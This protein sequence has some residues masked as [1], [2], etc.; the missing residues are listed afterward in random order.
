MR[1]ALTTAA[2]ASDEEAIEAVVAIERISRTAI[3]EIQR[4]QTQVQRNLA[5]IQR[6]ARRKRLAA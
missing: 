5:N 1:T 3:S 4:L 6:E 2:Q